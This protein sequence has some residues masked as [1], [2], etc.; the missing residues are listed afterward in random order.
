MRSKIKKAT[1]LS[2]K[3]KN[4]KNRQKITKQEKK[5]I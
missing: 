3:D 4:D 1:N 2:R 5:M